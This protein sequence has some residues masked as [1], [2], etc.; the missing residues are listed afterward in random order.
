M[1]QRSTRITC[2]QCA[3]DQCTA[4]RND[5]VTIRVHVVDFHKTKIRRLQRV[6]RA[7]TTLS[8]VPNESA[9]SKRSSLFIDL[10]HNMLECLLQVLWII[11]FKHQLPRGRRQDGTVDSK[12]KLATEWYCYVVAN[13][14][15]MSSLLLIQIPSQ[16]RRNCLQDSQQIF[17]QRGWFLDDKPGNNIRIRRYVFKRTHR[18]RRGQPSRYR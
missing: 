9:L 7:V 2:G 8:F 1:Q 13:V 16:L 10:S 17:N 15:T 14:E 18:R 12:S 3:F 6:E 5:H 4:G 11:Y